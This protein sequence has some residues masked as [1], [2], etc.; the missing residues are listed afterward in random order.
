MSGN[1]ILELKQ[2]KN[3]RDIYYTTIQ[4]IEALLPF[5]P[6]KDMAIWEPTDIDG[7]LNICHILK[8]RGYKVYYSGLPHDSL[9]IYDKNEENRYNFLDIYRKTPFES[10]DFFIVTNPPFSKN[11]DFIAQCYGRFCGNYFCEGFALLMP[12]SCLSGQKRGKLWGEILRRYGI[13]VYVFSK[14]I[15]FIHPKDLSEISCYFDCAWFVV[16]RDN[17]SRKIEVTLIK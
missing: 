17:T 15:K 2:R 8:Q 13:N 10:G 1:T 9:R 16:D 4:S 3:K 11:D 12:L 6:K 5:L 14:R 7:S